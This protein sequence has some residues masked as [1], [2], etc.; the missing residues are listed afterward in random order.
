[1]A[2]GRRWELVSNKL[3]VASM[4]AMLAG[5]MLAGAAGAAD[6]PSKTMEH[7]GATA[8]ADPNT[9]ALSISAGVDAVSE[10]WFRGIPQQDQGVILQPYATITA[11]LW[12]NDEFSLSAFVG[13][14]NSVHS[15]HPGVTGGWYEADWIFGAS[16]GLP[17]GFTLTPSFIIYHSPNGAWVETQEMD[18][19]LAYND[20]PLWG[21][22]GIPGWAGLQPYATLAFETAGGADSLGKAG[23]LG[24]YVELGITPAFTLIQSKDYPVTLKFPLKVGL[25]IDSYYEYTDVSSGSAENPTFGYFDG[26]IMAY[27]PL[28]FIP[29]EF[30]SWDLHGGVHFIVLNGDY[31]DNTIGSGYDE[32]RIVGTVGIGM[33]Y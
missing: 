14:W 29:A 15:E 27:V 10:Y 21:E 25:S 31:I 24:T 17:A 8:P 18:L 12:S 22:T 4:L 16:V 2:H 28:A 13:V 32:L 23:D 30:G 11:S 3:A 9:G 1:M 26:G 5:G 6:E 7:D 19:T 33:T 20:S